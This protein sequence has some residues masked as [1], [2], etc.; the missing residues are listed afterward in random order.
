MAIKSVAG[1]AVGTGHPA[2]FLFQP[3]ILSHL[4]VLPFCF[5]AKRGTFVASVL[6]ALVSVLSWVAETKL[7]AK[8]LEEKLAEAMAK[9]SSGA[10]ELEMLRKSETMLQE[11]VEAAEQFMQQQAAQIA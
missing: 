7:K 9:G 2:F 4:I 5:E 8:Q 3:S 1:S 6:T 10:D 11:K